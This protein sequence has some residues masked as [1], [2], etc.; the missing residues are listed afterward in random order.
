MQR[1][2]Q[3]GRQ[4]DRRIEFSGFAE[5]IKGSVSVRDVLTLNGIPINRSGF[6]VCPFHGDRDASL[7]VYDKGRGWVCYG[8]HKGGDVINLAMEL[9]G[10]G[11]Q[12]AIR[13]LNE[14]FSVGIEIDKQQTAKEAFQ[15]AANIAK[16]KA[17]WKSEQEK[18]EANERAYWKAFDKWLVLDRLVMDLENTFNHESDAFPDEFCKAIIQRNE[19][20]E[21]LTILEERRLIVHAK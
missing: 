3:S 21:D 10:V 11:F 5:R 14:E 20:Y 8:C 15:A 17:Q 6:A 13:K 12:D 16:L 18:A 1:R 19:A 4:R 7:K 9:Y 2:S